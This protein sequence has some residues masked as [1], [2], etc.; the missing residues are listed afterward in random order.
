MQSSD[1]KK[2]VVELDLWLDSRGGLLDAPARDELKARLDRCTKAIEVAIEDEERARIR[3][4]LLQI[5]ATLVS[6]F[7]NVM[8]LFNK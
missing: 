8:S 2:L 5:A 1:L 3:A 4:E 6:L 7:T